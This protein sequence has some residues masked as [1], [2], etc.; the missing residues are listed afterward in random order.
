MSYTIKLSQWGFLRSPTPRHMREGSEISDYSR[1][2]LS[3]VCLIATF[4][5]CMFLPYFFVWNCIW[6]F[7]YCLDMIWTYKDYSDFANRPIIYK[8]L[9]HFHVQLCGRYIYI[10]LF[11]TC[12]ILSQWT[13]TMGFTTLFQFLRCFF[14]NVRF[15]LI[16]IELLF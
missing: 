6:N 10:A 11:G 5:L 4:R 12:M 13:N 16:Y 2:I 7:V 14:P 3:L 9:S 1:F 15:I 8:L